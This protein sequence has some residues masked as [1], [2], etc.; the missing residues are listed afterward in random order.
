MDS[1]WFFLHCINLFPGLLIKNIRWCCVSKARALLAASQLAPPAT[2]SVSPSSRF[3][4]KDT[5]IALL[6]RT[7][8]EC[9]LTFHLTPPGG[10]QKLSFLFATK[11][12]H[13]RKQESLLT[14]SVVV[15]CQYL[16]GKDVLYE[17]HQEYFA[18]LEGFNSKELYW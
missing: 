18:V 4:G 11:E 10:V 2:N 5:Y 15:L 17:A 6:E 16:R 8:K 13:S 3:P 12:Q 14:T 1:Q 7:Q 9:V